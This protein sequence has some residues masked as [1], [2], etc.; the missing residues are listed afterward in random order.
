[1]CCGVGCRL[2]S[3][4]TVSVRSLAATALT[5]SLAWESPYA[6]EIV[7]NRQ[8]KKKKKRLQVLSKNSLNKI[9]RIITHT[10]IAR[11]LPLLTGAKKK[12]G[13]RVLGEGEIIALLLCQA[14]EGHSRLM[15]QRLC[16]P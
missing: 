10:I 5:R 2:R 14:K 11:T 7:L 13:D 1:M 15:P 3:C 12:H 16:P 9:L 6:E 8:K 4:I